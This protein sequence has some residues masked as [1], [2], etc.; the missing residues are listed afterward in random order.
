MCG[1][2]VYKSIVST[3]LIDKIAAAYGINVE[4]TLTGFKN[5]AVKI[6]ALCRKGREQDFLFGFEESLG[7][8]YGTYTRDKDG[9]MACQLICLAAA[10]CKSLGITLSDRLNQIHQE[11]GFIE[12]RTDAL[13]FTMEKDREVMDSIMKRLF[14]GD[15][16]TVNEKPVKMDATYQKENVFQGEISEGDGRV[17]RFIL[18]PS[19]TELKLKM[20]V[21]AEGASRQA[22]GAKAAAM[23]EEIKRYLVC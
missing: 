3:P 17:H 14:H 20:Y 6:E 10:R 12:S 18:R 15:L 21:F 1:K 23:I 11:Y 16:K 7:Y 9:V 4:S 13:Y 8:L 19:G 22:A 5:I 2:Y